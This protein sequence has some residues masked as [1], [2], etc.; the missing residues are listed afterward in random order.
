MLGDGGGLVGFEGIVRNQMG[1]YRIRGEFRTARPL[2]IIP[3][4]TLVENLAW[5]F[6][7]FSTAS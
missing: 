2:H 6:W 7:N 1:F 3:S 5:N 4:V